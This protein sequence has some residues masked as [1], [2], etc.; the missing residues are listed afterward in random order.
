MGI[1]LLELKTDGEARK[2]L[3]AQSTTENIIHWQDLWIDDEKL[4]AYLKEHPFP[5]DNEYTEKNFRDDLT[6]EGYICLWVE[7]EET[8][9]YI[10]DLI[11]EL[12]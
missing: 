12:I 11:H 9:E 10:A 6:C 7:K 5:T 2:F 1:R 4:E 8:A 3:L